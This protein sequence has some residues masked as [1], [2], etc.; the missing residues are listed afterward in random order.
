MVTKSS[1]ALTPPGRHAIVQKQKTAATPQD[2]EEGVKTTL[3]AKCNWPLLQLTLAT[4]DCA[5]PM[6]KYYIALIDN[7]AS[8]HPTSIL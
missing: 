5:R 6:N 7:T 4:I 3:S 2:N 8:R 1:Y